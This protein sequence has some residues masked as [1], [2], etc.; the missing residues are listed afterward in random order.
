MASV[1][2]RDIFE[3]YDQWGQRVAFNE[4][5]ARKQIADARQAGSEAF[6]SGVDRKTARAAYFEKRANLQ[7]EANDFI[8]DQPASVDETA[9]EPVDD[10]GSV[11]DGEE[12]L[13]MESVVAGE[14][15]S[16]SLSSYENPDDEYTPAQYLEIMAAAQRENWEET[17][18]GN[19]PEFMSYPV[20]YMDSI[21]G[22][23]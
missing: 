23:R 9:A 3:L 11:T 8:N 20:G 19:D 17:L 6:T 14:T 10:L 1:L 16:A 21:D 13:G 22:N 4:G 2:N 15:E 18:D 12:T 5:Y 7:S